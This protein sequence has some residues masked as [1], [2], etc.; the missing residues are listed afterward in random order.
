M[1]V[2]SSS[3]TSKNIVTNSELFTSDNLKKLSSISALEENLAPDSSSTTN[4][5][6]LKVIEVLYQPTLFFYS[7]NITFCF[8]ALVVEMIICFL[9]SSKFEVDCLMS[10]KSTGGTSLEIALW[11]KRSSPSFL[12]SIKVLFL[13]WLL[14]N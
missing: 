13:S 1:Y 3:S 8:L 9:K 10:D 2:I 4:I 6:V 7:L 14:L 12:M 5:I 11:S